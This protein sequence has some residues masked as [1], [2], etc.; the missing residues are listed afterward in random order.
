MD[1][2]QK[3]IIWFQ[4]TGKY[5]KIIVK[6]EKK[7]ISGAIVIRCFHALHLP[8]DKCLWV[9]SVLSSLS[10]CQQS[11]G[12]WLS[13][14]WSMHSHQMDLPT[15][16]V[17]DFQL[18]GLSWRNAEICRLIAR[19]QKKTQWHDSSNRNESIKS[20]N[21][22]HEQ[23]CLNKETQSLNVALERGWVVT[24]SSAC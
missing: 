22:P 21:T 3:W 7:Q 9:V 14:T 5:Y 24:L 18:W 2:N 15:V 13:L 20:T 10:P 4:S 12:E 16:R 11:V 1:E 23:K 19:F 17:I 8:G 6:G